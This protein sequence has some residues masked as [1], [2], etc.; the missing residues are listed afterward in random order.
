[1]SPLSSPG[2]RGGRGAAL[3][4]FMESCCASPCQPWP[5]PG[6]WRHCCHLPCQG[7]RSCSAS[8]SCVSGAECGTHCHSWPMVVTGTSAV[9][10]NSHPRSTECSKLE[11]THQDQVQLEAVH[12]TPQESHH[13]PESL[14][15]TLLELWQAWGRHHCLEGPVLQPLREEPFAN[16]TLLPLFSFMTC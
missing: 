16:T 5:W 4:L 1:M 3:C 8:A 2:C 9:P 11:D 13:G 14:G 15:Q 10:Q 6:H 12:S 7:P